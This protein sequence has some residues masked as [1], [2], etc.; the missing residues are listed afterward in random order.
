MMGWRYRAGL[1]MIGAFVLIWVTSAEVTQ[2]R[3]WFSR[4]Y[5]FILYV[6]IEKNRAL[7]RNDGGFD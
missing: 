5:M 1:G 4:P 7:T 6:Y 2:V 3:P